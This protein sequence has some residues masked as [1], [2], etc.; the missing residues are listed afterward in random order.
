V[1]FGGSQ[2]APLAGKLIEEYLKTE[3][4]RTGTLQASLSN[5]GRDEGNIVH[6]RNNT[7]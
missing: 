1:G 2:A 3:H 7:R 6:A 5:D 4:M